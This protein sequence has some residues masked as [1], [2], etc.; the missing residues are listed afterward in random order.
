MTTKVG[1]G[2]LLLC[3]A[4]SANA[5]ISCSRSIISCGCT[6][7]KAG[8]YSVDGDLSGLQGL[9][10]LNACID[11]SAA[12]AKLFLNGHLVEGIEQDF[13]ATAIHVL[14]TAKYTVIEGSTATPPVVNQII[15]GW[16]IGIESDAEN[17]VIDLPNIPGVITAGV[18]LN[19]TYNNRVSGAGPN[20]VGTS[21]NGTYGIWIAGGNSNQVNAGYAQ[22]NGIAAVY[23]GCSSTGPTGT[24]CGRQGA[25]S[26][27]LIYNYRS[28]SP[29][30]Q[31]FQPYGIVLEAGSV[32]NTVMNT[33]V[34]GDSVFDLY[35]GNPGCADNVWR[36]NKF[37]IANQNCI[38]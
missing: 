37:S 26:G 33:T 12:H 38:H 16:K 28:A 10:A 24:P 3:V 30:T 32:H 2:L 6:I 5:Q 34:S 7:T 35:D 25:S 18:F 15:G 27:N 13:D 21:N 22:Y 11:I 1:L 31:Q 29:G 23:V 36:V 19:H 8:N 14:Q 4:G 20:G 9:T 17:V